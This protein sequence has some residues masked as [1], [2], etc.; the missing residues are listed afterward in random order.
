MTREAGVLIG[1]T[2]KLPGDDITAGLVGELRFKR[3]QRRNTEDK[4]SALMDETANVAK[5][6]ITVRN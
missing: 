3:G 1:C 4:Y 2:H 6:N 5:H